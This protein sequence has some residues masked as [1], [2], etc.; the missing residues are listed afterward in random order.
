[1]IK[2]NENLIIDEKSVF[3]IEKI[4]DYDSEWKNKKHCITI[5]FHPYCALKS[6]LIEY[7][8]E[9]NRDDWFLRICEQLCR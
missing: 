2:I 6:R 4:T 3:S 5:R 8:D 7:T 1:M 9:D